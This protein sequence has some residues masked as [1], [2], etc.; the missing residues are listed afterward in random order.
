MSRY[1]SA[2]EIFEIAVQLGCPV[3]ASHSNAS[4]VCPVSRNLT[5]AQI[6][7]ILAS[8]GVIGLNLY[9]AFLCKDGNA[10]LSDLIPHIEYFLEHGA[11][12][13]LCFGGD[14]DG[15]ELPSE[16]RTIADITQIAELLLARNYSESFVRNL[17]FEN[18]YA[19]C[20][21]YLSA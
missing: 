16:L 21:R 12:H 1:R 11:E 15:A 8:D 5:D 3:I 7:K 19:F 6:A 2:D 14:W 4:T 10:H 18:A 20:K 9:T 13:A 17:F